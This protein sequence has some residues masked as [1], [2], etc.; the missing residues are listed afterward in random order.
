MELALS[1]EELLPIGLRRYF[2]TEEFTIVPN[3]KLGFLENLRYIAFG[4]SSRY[5]SQE[6]IVNALHPQ[7]VSEYTACSE[8]HRPCHM[9]SA[10]FRPQLSKFNSKQG[11]LHLT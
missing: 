10:F 7:P 9:E 8:Q 4:E 1:V 6:N 11:T 3:R 2:I 5:D